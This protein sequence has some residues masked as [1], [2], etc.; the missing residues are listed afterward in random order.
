[1]AKKPDDLMMPISEIVQM[2]RQGKNK[3]QMLGIL[4]DMNCCSKGRI[5]RVLEE[6]GQSAPQPYGKG[7]SMKEDKTVAELLEKENE[8]ALAVV[9]EEDTDAVRTALGIAIDVTDEGIEECSKK[10]TDIKRKMQQ[11]GDE[12]NDAMKERDGLMK[13]DERFRKELARF[14]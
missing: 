1:M 12:L 10:I 5:A 6:N 9:P 3:T 11:L 4:A 14:R 8:K 2:Y 7:M 13:L